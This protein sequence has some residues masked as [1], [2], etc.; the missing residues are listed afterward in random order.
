MSIGIHGHG[1]T[2]SIGGTAIGNIVSISG[3]SISRDSI[4]ISTMDSSSK[5]REFIP[6]MI[7]AGEITCDVNYDGTTVSALLAAQLTATAQTIKVNLDSDGS[8]TGSGF[9][10]SLGHTIPFDDKI[11]QSVGIKLTGALTH[12]TATT[13]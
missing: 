13:S 6:G 11:Q 10:T 1:S 12:S 8:F 3:P 7:D 5:W 2:L 4:D 9:I